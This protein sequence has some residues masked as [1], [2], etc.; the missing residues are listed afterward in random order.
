M[1]EFND[2]SPR[3]TRSFRLLLAAADGDALGQA[4]GHFLRERQVPALGRKVIAVDGKTLRGSRTTKQPAT[5]LLATMTRC[6]Q[7]LAQRQIYGTG[8]WLI[9]VG[10]GCW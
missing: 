7:V 2:A 3:R 8:G 9:P 1:T 6:G 10:S 4:I 5:A